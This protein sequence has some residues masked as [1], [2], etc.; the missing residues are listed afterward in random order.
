MKITITGGT[1][2]FGQQVTRHLLSSAQVQEI[3]IVSRDEGKQED[4]RQRMP[5]PRLRYFIADVRDAGSLRTA[6]IGAD[7]VFHAAALKQVPS[8]EFFPEQAVLTNV[9]G[10][11]NV[12]R[13]A[14]EEGV[15]RVVCLSTDKAV[16]PVN[17]M[18]M[19]K[20]LMEKTVQAHARRLGAKAATTLCCVRYGNVLYSR[21]SVVPLFMERLLSGQPLPVTDPRM[22][23]FLLPLAEAVGLVEMA[24]SHGRQGD[25]F[26]R[27]SAACD[28]ATLVAALAELTGL[29]PEEHTIGVR[30]GEKLHET[31][32]SSEEMAKAEDLGEHWRIPM[33]LRGLDYRPDTA[34][35]G[36]V[37]DTPAFASDNAHRMTVQEVTALFASLPEIQ[38]SLARRSA[39]GG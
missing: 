7:A 3:R 32:A 31:L 11:E 2:S 27:K 21:G 39:S 9:L 30:H 8:C 13:V 28:V 18:G 24:L 6:F 38:A 23:R 29:H 26:I 34:A 1:G 10:S 20:A 4:M 33:D 25:T 5:D 16:Q 37:A 15:A 17:A 22:T 36:P 12:L 19:T 14:Q 35:P